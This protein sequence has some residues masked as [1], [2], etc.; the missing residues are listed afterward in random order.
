MNLK[1]SDPIS[2]KA[3]W[4]KPGLGIMYQIE[5]RPGWKW[6]RNFNKFNKS[7]R[8]RNGK[9]NFNGPYCQMAEWVNLSR[10]I[11][12]DYHIF[13]AK[14]H[15]G[16]VWFN[17]SLTGWKTPTDYAGQFAEESRKCGIS[18]M[19]YYSSI[20]DHN[21]QFQDI[22]PINSVTPSFP[23][24]RG[25][26][27]REYLEGHMREMI[28]QYH[29]DGIWLDW[30]TL[31]AHPSEV[32]VVNFLRQY[33]PR[34]VIAF[35]FTNPFVEERQRFPRNKSGPRGF[36]EMLHVV[37]HLIAAG[38]APQILLWTIAL[39]FTWPYVKLF[40]LKAQRPDEDVIDYIHYS[41]SEAHTLKAA[42]LESNLYRRL[43][44]PWEII[45]PAGTAWDAM[46]IRKDP[47]DLVRIVATTMANGGRYVIGAAAR[48]DGSLYPDQ[49]EQLRLVGKW[50]KPRRIF[51]SEATP[52]EYGGTRVPGLSGYRDGM[53]AVGS[54]LG[55]DYLVHLIN[56]RGSTDSKT[57]RFD[58]RIWPQID[59]AY[60]EPAHKELTTQRAPG[61]AR[62]TIS[63]EDID[64]V[65]TLLRIRCVA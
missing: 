55:R 25:N 23:K 65:D 15:D 19:F 33:S 7:M 9:F 1:T 13:E 17:T 61:E 40:D 18:F 58:S 29:P 56:F 20:I 35:H 24:M 34:T 3:W 36:W 41:T 47:Y 62:V 44:N 10:E 50:Y 28:D 43:K 21:P 48:M 52:M 46:A 8:D 38:H 12:A 37:R 26:E 31:G 60:L 54:R 11:G 16:I 6:N 63:K 39:T 30:Y 42:W 2:N 22:V 5:F 53:G 59:K 45:G 27:Y 49:V 32:V 64:L 57:L 4:Q 14:W 51:F